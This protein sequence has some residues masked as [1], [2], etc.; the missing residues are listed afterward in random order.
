VQTAADLK[1]M[2]P[3]ENYFLTSDIDLTTLI[4]DWAGP[5]DYN[6]HFNGNGRKVTLGLS[7]GNTDTGLFGSLAGGAIIENLQVEVKT[8][9]D[10]AILMGTISFGGVVGS[11][12][13]SGTYTIRGV[14]V[15]GT[16]NYTET[17][18]AP[19]LLV[20]GIIGRALKEST[21]SGVFLT[22]EN[23]E[24]DL[25]ITFNIPNYYS[26]SV[27]A[28]GGI[29]GKFGD[30]I[31]EVKILN[32]RTGGSITTSNMKNTISAGG[33]IGTS[34]SNNLPNGAEI[35][36]SL[37]IKNC[38]STTQ[39]SVSSRS[40]TDLSTAG[41]IVGFLNNKNADIQNNI[42]LN[43]SIVAANNDNSGSNRK[44][45]RVI[46]FASTNAATY[47]NN[48]ALDATLV[49]LTDAA[50]AVVASG[51]ADNINGLN[52]TA[53]ELSSSSF[54]KDEGFADTVWDFTG[55][56][57]ANKVYPKLKRN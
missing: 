36:G 26:L 9:K 23:C 28:I 29:I 32:C 39:I 8:L 10:N 7:S 47:S 43:P 45:G 15:S 21:P 44:A 16:L 25:Q 41:G 31:G 27:V 2:S 6:G 1:N 42:A 20:G 11:I 35:N 40:T 3:G 55:L 30:D 19:S 14:S 18:S 17:I 37:I 34:D 53:E 38:Y 49:G 57:I 46:G 48:Y 12:L 52:K 4:G 24:S 33:I 50:K 54:W 5:K 22:I 51:A 13:N 56:D